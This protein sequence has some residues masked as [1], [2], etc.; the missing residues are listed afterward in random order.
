[1]LWLVTHGGGVEEGW[2]VKW[3]FVRAWIRGITQV[4]SACIYY[5]GGDLVIP[6]HCIYHMYWYASF[7][8]PNFH[9][10]DTKAFSEFTEAMSVN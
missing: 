2:S 5:R 4:K 8:L 3:Q 1:M 7:V 6:V 10:A 9:S